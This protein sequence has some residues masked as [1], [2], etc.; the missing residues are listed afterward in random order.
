MRSTPPS[1]RQARE[2]EHPR[3]APAFPMTSD[4]DVTTTPPEAPSARLDPGRRARWI[5][6]AALV[7]I[8]L[9]AVA[10]RDVGDRGAIVPAVIPS[11]AATLGPTVQLTLEL[12][13]SDAVEGV[14]VELSAGGE[15]LAQHEGALPI[16]LEAPREVPLVLRVEAP[17]RA[18]YAEPLMLDADRTLRVPLPPGARIAG[19]VVDER[20]EAIAGAAVQ[21]TREESEDH[22][23]LTQSDGEGRFDVDTLIAGTYRVEA[24]ARGHSTTARQGVEPGGDPLRLTLERVG[25]VGGRVVLPDGSG[26][27]GATIVIAGSGIWPARQVEADAEGR[28]RITNVPPGVYEVRAFSGGLVAEPRRGLDVEPGSPAYLTFALVAGV[29]FRGVIRDSVSGRPIAGAAISVSTEELDVAPRATTSGD[30]GRFTVSGLSSGP[31]RVSVFAEGYVPV[32]ALEHPGGEPLELDLEPAATIAGIVL[33][34][35]RRP[36]VGA[37]IEIVGETADRQPVALGPEAGFRAAVFASHLEPTDAPASAAALEVVPGPVAPIPLAPTELGLAVAPL[38]PS[39]EEIRTSAAY[40]SDEEGRFRVSGIPPGHVQVIARRVGRAP[41]ATAR[42]FV[43]AGGVRDDVELVLPPAGRLRGTIEDGRGDAAEGVLVEVRSDREPYPRLAFSDDRGEFELDDV[44]G[45]LT[46]TAMPQGRPAVRTTATVRSSASAEVALVLE[47]ELHTLS[48]RT[49]DEAGFPVPRTQLAVVSLRADAPFRRTFFAA[50]D[51]TFTLSELPAPPW[52]IEA[53]DPAFAPARVDVARAEGDLEVRLASGAE[54]RGSVLDDYSG[55]GVAARV[56]LS[57]E[58]LPPELREVACGGDGA[59]SFARVPAGSWR[60]SI[61]SDRHLPHHQDVV[62][63]TARGQRELALDPIRLAPSGWLEGSVVDAL[64]APVSRATVWL[65]EATSARTDSR[66]EFVL[67]GASA[68]DVVVHA[69]HP[70][71]GEGASP[72]V[73]VLAG[74]ETI[75]VI[76]RLPERFDPERAEALPGRQRGVALEL[77]GARGAIRIRS[78]IAGSHAERAGLREGD[79]LEEIDGIEPESARG[80]AALLRGAAGVPAVIRLRRGDERATVLVEREGW[81]PP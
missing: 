69:S 43:A 10:L 29:P 49:V 47:G 58:G 56:R 11:A 61:E 35:D 37:T 9:G 5:R 60:L 14:R 80:A 39:P 1:P 53:S 6:R 40:L 2:P 59:F 63:T 54:L 52:R 7:A 4:D 64:G 27:E 16:V 34:E 8:C 44:F 23:W 38:P 68:G 71:A 46:V 31:R 33:D 22:P 57:R 74:R 17:G 41:Q 73:R 50:E 62:I 28:F 76:V 13:S 72:A 66:G 45:E 19:S 70:A 3:A 12:G 79:V 78:V 48:G 81:L 24:S 77:E 75:G 26:A 36:I 18:R 42:L 30:D 55:E 21:L 20:G 32:A 67:R 15:V 51:G 25:L 65:D